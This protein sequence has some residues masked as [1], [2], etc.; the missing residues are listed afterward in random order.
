MILFQSLR[1]KILNTRFLS[2]KVNI[3]KMLIEVSIVFYFVPNVSSSFERRYHHVTFG[4]VPSNCCKGTVLFFKFPFHH[5][6]PSIFGA[7]T[8]LISRLFQSVHAGHMCK[9]QRHTHKHTHTR[10]HINAIPFCLLTSCRSLVQ[11][12]H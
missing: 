4:K 1:R 7:I 3:C 5:N 6:E 10:R 11:L 12:G 2:L 8:T 9:I